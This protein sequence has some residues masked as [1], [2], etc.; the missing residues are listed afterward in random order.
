MKSVIKSLISFGVSHADSESEK[1]NIIMTNAIALLV[2]SAP[3]LLI[4]TRNFYAPWDQLLYL[5]FVISSGFFL[6]PLLLN[7]LGFIVGSRI[8]LCWQPSL[9][10]LILSISDLRDDPSATSPS[11][12]VGV[13]LFLLAFACFPF[14]VFNLQ[15][16]GLVIIGSLAPLLAIL[17]FDPI[18]TFFEVGFWQRG[19]SDPLYAFNNMRALISFLTI[20]LSCFILKRV[21]EQSEQVNEHLMKELAE[22]N[23][24]IQQQA[25]DEL[26]QLN[27]Q[28]LANLTQLSEREFILNQ[29]QRI[30]KIGSWEYTLKNAFFFWSDEMYNILGVD[31][32]FDLQN[33]NLWQVL[34]GDEGK[35]LIDSMVTLLRTGK[36][37]DVTLRTKTPIGYHK[38]MRVYAFPIWADGHIKGARGICHDIT[39]YKEADEMLRTSEYKYRSLFEQATDAIFITDFEGNFRDVNASLCKMFGYTREELLLSNIAKVIEPNH[40]KAKPI[41]FDL[42]AVGE[43]VTNERYMVHK[44]GTIRIVEANVKKFRENEIMAIVRDVTELRKVQNNV[45]INEAKFRG[46]FEDSSIGM[47]LVS[48]EGNYLKVNREL[49]SILGY[50]EH[51]LHSI[52]LQNTSHPE[53]L[54]RVLEALHRILYG[55]LQSDRMEVRKRNKAGVEVW[56]NLNISLIR[57]ADGNPLYF[58][59]QIENITDRR[60]AEEKFLK[61][62]DLGPDLMFIIRE[63]DLVFVEANR[64]L[65]EVSG[66]TRSEVIGFSAQM[67]H[68]EI[69]ANSDERVRFFNTYYEHGK[70]FQEAEFRK[71]NGDTFFA[72]ISA[73][74]VI[75]TG[76]NHLIVI[77]RD[78][79]KQREYQEKLIVSEA[80]LNATI[81]NTEVMIWSVDRNFKLLTFNK[82]FAKYMK[83][84]YGVEVQI[85][86]FESSNTPI[87]VMMREKWGTLYKKALL[88]EVL[89]VEETRFEKDFQYSISPIIEGEHIIGVSVFADNVTERK[90]RD[91]ELAEANKKIG[92]LK[93]MA[94]RSVMSPHFIFNVLNSIQFYIAKNDRLNA[95]NYLSTFSKLIRS[96]LTHSVDNKIKLSE[97]VEMLKN[98]VQLEMTRFENRFDFEIHV[99]ADLDTSSIE[100]PSLLIQPYVENA[101]LHGLYNKHEKGTLSIRIWEKDQALVFEIEDDGIGREAAMKLRGQ[102]FQPHISMGIKLTEERLKL[103][104][105]NHHTAFEIEDLKDENGPCGT[106]V[107]IQ[108]LLD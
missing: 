3:I 18:F 79:T 73:Q 81:N 28:L 30:A 34:W 102:N 87:A 7:R 89:T 29:S 62:F 11:S 38:W 67:K 40:L 107:R 82:R 9:F 96:I 32:S 37:Y 42:L 31:R 85:G 50:L 23:K 6:I 103:I 25:E 95:I 86:F 105:A 45:Q 65:E 5:K 57:N 77:V 93:L 68:I 101:I 21:V 60:A 54:E 35:V 56:V 83:D 27:Q 22:K 10:V 24:L 36:P 97:E 69:W 2:A 17:F 1:R 104:N 55:S 70:V 46:A 51:E 33:R 12:F 15:K 8:I 63:G 49:C 90:A 64:K 74:R 26:Y 48:P 75:M 47:A 39:Y 66:F 72:T 20:S 16:F 53:D 91:R 84:Q 94:L 44:D 106:R 19:I 100:I 41:R 14:L 4:I 88:G 52:R 92:Q 71:K 80:N 99:D 59:M 58:V 108:V 78:I 98:Y 61:A 43:H 13:R 76:E